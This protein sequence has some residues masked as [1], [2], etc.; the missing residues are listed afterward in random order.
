MKHA[1]D[2]VEIDRVESTVQSYLVFVHA[3]ADGL[4]TTDGV[5]AL[6]VTAAVGQRN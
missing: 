1:P 2:L 3:P 4:L 6:G 5:A